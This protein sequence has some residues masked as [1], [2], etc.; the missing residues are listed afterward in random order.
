MKIISWNVNGVRAAHKKGFLDWV[1]EA[2]ADVICI[3]ETKA[4]ADKIPDEVKGLNGY[5]TY[6]HSCSIKSGYSGVGVLSRIK[7]ENVTEKIGI[8]EFDGEGRILEIDYGS[9]LLY[10]IYFPNGSSGNKRVPFKLRFYDAVMERWAMQRAEGRSILVCGDYNIAHKPIDL[11][12]PKENEKTTGFLPEERAI[13]DEMAAGGWVDTFREFHPDEPDWYS[14][15]DQITRARERNVGWRID[16]HW[17][18]EDLRPALK[19][20][21]ISTDVMGSDHCPVGVVLNP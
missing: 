3:Q 20:A 5:H 15:W 13:L 1:A 2:K 8:D 11:A 16:Y 7:P 18:T 14:Y 19:N 9:F 12:R 6:W 4:D 21:W 17:I 10:N